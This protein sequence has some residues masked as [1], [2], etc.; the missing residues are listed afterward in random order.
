MPEPDPD[1][2]GGMPEPDPDIGGSKPE[3]D[4]DG[5]GDGGDGGDGGGGIRHLWPAGALVERQ[6]KVNKRAI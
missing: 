4:R 1:L 3:P 2:G 6:T 5:G